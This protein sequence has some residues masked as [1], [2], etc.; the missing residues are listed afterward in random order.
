MQQ[1]LASEAGE[2]HCCGFTRQPA[3]LLEAAREVHGRGCIPRAAGDA[4]GASGF[5]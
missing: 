1:G 2:P 5:L 3:L 4:G